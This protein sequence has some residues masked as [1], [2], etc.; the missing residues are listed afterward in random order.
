MGFGAGVSL[1]AHQPGQGE[2]HRLHGVDADPAGPGRQRSEAQGVLQA[3]PLGWWREGDPGG[4]EPHGV[5]LRLQGQFVYLHGREF[6]E[7][8]GFCP[9]INNPSLMAYE[10]QSSA[11]L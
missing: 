7:E 9:V 6:S 5:Q 11:L 4:L 10:F 8:A 1:G 2:G 3:D